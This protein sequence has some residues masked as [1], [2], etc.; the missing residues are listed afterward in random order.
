MAFR[1]QSLG[2]VLLEWLCL[3]WFWPDAGWRHAQAM[4]EYELGW[5]SKDLL[6]SVIIRE[7]GRTATWLVQWA[8]DLIMIQTGLQQVAG[9]MMGYAQ[10]TRLPA[11]SFDI[12]Y[13]V[14]WLMIQSQDY[15]LAALYTVLTFCIRLVILTLT[16]PLFVLAAFTGLVDGLVRRD[17][18]KFGLG[19]ES[20]YLK[21]YQISQP[22]LSQRFECIL[23]DEGQ[24][25]NPVIADLVKTQQ[26][27]KVTVGDPH[28]QI[29]RFRGAEDAHGSEW[30][31]GAEK[32]YLTQ[33][34]RHRRWQRRHDGQRRQ[35]GQHFSR[36]RLERQP[37][38]RKYEPQHYP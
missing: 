27:R 14:G 32:H 22:D 30:M 23:L 36:R 26:I 10:S 29:Y 38:L 28:Q 6:Q 24:D 8:Y 16:I 20:S 35:H 1:H 19:R 33:S 21:L 3:Y 34:F 37:G 9:E 11:D 2:A 15:G 17:L 12:R 31:A 7:P 25:V 5:L 13:Y 4:F 18:R